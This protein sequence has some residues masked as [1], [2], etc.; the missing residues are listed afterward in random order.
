MHMPF[1]RPRDERGAAL[2]EFALVFPIFVF[3]L[4]GLIAYGMA[5]SLKQ[6]I[7]HAAA[8]GARAALGAT[9]PSSC[10][11]TPYPYG[12][13]PQE[14]AWDTAAVNQVKGA[15]S[16]MGSNEQYVTTT[17]ST[18]S[19]CPDGNANS[20]CITV[21]ISYDYGDHPLVPNLPGLGLVTP[22]QIT[23]TAV[24]EVQ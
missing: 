6:S 7:T 18:A 12:T 24:V 9:V 1:K 15:L 10:T 17:P 11:T 21:A 23:S 2:L 5:L 3:V 20:E 16:W 8:E 22:N 14:C 13:T 19:P 4:Y